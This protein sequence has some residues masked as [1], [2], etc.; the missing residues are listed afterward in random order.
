MRTEY[1]KEKEMSYRLECKY[2][3]AGLTHYV[4]QSEES[5]F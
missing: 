2:R 5:P 4:M 3:G 1:A